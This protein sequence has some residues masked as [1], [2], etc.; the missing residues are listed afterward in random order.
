MKKSI[1]IQK[2]ILV[3]F[4][5]LCGLNILFAQENTDALGGMAYGTG[6]SISYSIGQIDYETTSGPGGSITEGLQQPIEILTITGF[7][8][9][10]I[11]LN[12]EIFPNPTTDFVVLSVYNKKTVNMFY[13]IYNLDGKLIETQE[14]AGSQT[15]IAMKELS[16]GIYFIKVMQKSSEIKVF[17]V[18]KNN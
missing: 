5:V 12:F 10:N 6:G 8:D 9:N 2:V 1:H 7:E 15:T 16:N 17:K 4:S 11:N 3:F 14:L 18:I 13:T